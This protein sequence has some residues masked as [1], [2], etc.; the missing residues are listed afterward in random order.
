MPRRSQTS[1][2]LLEYSDDSHVEAWKAAQAAQH[3]MTESETAS[4]GQREASTAQ[5]PKTVRETEKAIRDA[6]AAMATLRSCAPDMLDQ[7][8]EKVDRLHKHLHAL[9]SQEAE[10]ASPTTSVSADRAAIAALVAAF[11]IQ[12]GVLFMARRMIV[13][14]EKQLEELFYLLRELL[15]PDLDA[16]VKQAASDRL[17]DELRAGLHS[18]SSKEAAAALGA[19]LSAANLESVPLQVLR[20]VMLSLGALPNDVLSEAVSMSSDAVQLSDGLRHILRSLERL[21]GAGDGLERVMRAV[22][23]QMEVP[24]SVKIVRDQVKGFVQAM[25][26]RASLVT[27]YTEVS[28]VRQQTERHRQQLNQHSKQLAEMKSGAHKRHK[29]Q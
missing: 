2:E 27:L 11:Q 14:Y 9:Q 13:A 4:N 7:L 10:A 15:P 24:D 28:Q 6:E 20:E 23:G 16:A 1:E 22:T 12:S 17:H 5:L 19:Q 8:A 25:Q 21:R 29:R 3:D 18:G 26:D